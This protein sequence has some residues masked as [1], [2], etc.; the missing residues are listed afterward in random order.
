[1]DGDK[2]HVALDETATFSSSLSLGLK[3]LQG[4][5]QCPPKTSGGQAS[6]FMASVSTRLVQTTGLSEGAR[7]RSHNRWLSNCRC[8]SRRSEHSILL[9]SMR[10]SCQLRREAYMRGCPS[11]NGTQIKS[12]R[13]SGGPLD[14][15]YRERGYTS[16]QARNLVGSGVR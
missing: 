5:T 1:M 7:F 11:R 14:C 16:P 3:L 15:D 8:R 6:T 4:T 2:R 13:T 10:V 9:R 12:L